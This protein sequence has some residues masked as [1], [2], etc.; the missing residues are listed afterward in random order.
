MTMNDKKP[1]LRWLSTMPN[2]RVYDASIYG[3]NVGVAPCACSIIE[4]KI[5]PIRYT[6]KP[7]TLAAFGAIQ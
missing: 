1:F 5:D 6:A 4:I 7:T 2:N 3:C